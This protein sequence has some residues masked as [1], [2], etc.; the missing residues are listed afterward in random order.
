MDIFCFSFFSLVIL[1]SV[2]VDFVCFLVFG[3]FFVYNSVHYTFCCWVTFSF[4][5]WKQQCFPLITRIP[6]LF[7]SILQ[8]NIFRLNTDYPK[9]YKC[10]RRK[11]TLSI[12]GPTIR[13][14]ILPIYFMEWK[15]LF[16]HHSLEKRQIQSTKNQ[17]SEKEDSTF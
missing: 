17:P 15:M 2:L 1:C 5:F 9:V 13:E 14:E 11:L 16:V 7:I 10:V 8:Y 12:K 4:R 3:I 6:F